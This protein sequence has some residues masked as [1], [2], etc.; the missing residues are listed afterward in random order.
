MKKY[1]L[2]TP[3]RNEEAYIEKSIESIV[4]QTL[5]PAQ[6][7][8]VSDRS[9]DRTDAVA[10]HYAARHPFIKLITLPA[11]QGRDFGSKVSAFKTGYSALSVADYDYI[12]N[13]DADVS[14]A[15]DYYERIIERFEAKERLGIAGGVIL[16]LMG[17]EFRKQLSGKNS[18]AGAVQFFSRRCFE[19]IGGYVPIKFGGIDSAAEIMARMKGWEVSA[20]EELEVYHHR[21]VSGSSG[22]FKARFRSGMMHYQLGYHPLF[23]VVSA[24]Y[25]LQDPPLIAG[26]LLTLFGYCW[27]FTR[28]YERPVSRTFI[29]YLTAEQK[30][31]LRSILN[32]KL[33]SKN[34]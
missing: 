4:S 29:D 23:Q 14:F 20:F 34:P 18:V 33:S 1:V 6:W 3:A 12:G 28:R 15:P 24:V 10:A 17:K 7:V 32:L 25:R 11:G 2:I 26:S 9:T 13:L 16:E 5:R 27:A 30:A 21:R 8:I 31:R 22:I 19:D